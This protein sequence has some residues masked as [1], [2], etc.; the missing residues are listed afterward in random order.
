M[1]YATGQ[2]DMVKR[3]GRWSSDAVYA[4][5]RDNAEATAASGGTAADGNALLVMLILLVR[6]KGQR[7]FALQG[8]LGD[9]QVSASSIG[10][11]SVADPDV[12][13]VA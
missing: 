4:Y 1:L 12:G 9:T 5:P 8:V 13:H 10:W 11:L 7:L 2:F 3:F 6:R